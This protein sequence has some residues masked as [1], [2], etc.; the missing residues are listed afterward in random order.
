[1]SSE[2]KIKSE[3]SILKEC[4]KLMEPY[5]KEKERK[6]KLLSTKLKIEKKEAE[7]LKLKHDKIQD[8]VIKAVGNYKTYKNIKNSP[9]AITPAFFLTQYEYFENISDEDKEILGKVNDLDILN[10]TSFDE[11]LIRVATEFDNSLKKII[12]KNTVLFEHE[13]SE[14]NEDVQNI[15]LNV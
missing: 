5:E 10:A 7:L 14:L 13:W 1:M 3:L 9:N 15:K 4:E 2:S 6:K 12:N 8:K 11:Q